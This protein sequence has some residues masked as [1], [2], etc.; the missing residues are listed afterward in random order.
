MEPL[1]RSA[2]ASANISLA[3]YWRIW[4]ER[5]QLAAIG[6]TGR[7]GGQVFGQPV[8]NRHHTRGAHWRRPGRTGSDGV[9]R[10]AAVKAAR[11]G[12]GGRLKAH[13]R[14]M[15]SR[16][17]LGLH[18]R[19]ANDIFKCSSGCS[20]GSAHDG[21]RGRRGPSRRRSSPVHGLAAECGRGRCD[22]KRT[23]LCSTGP[24]GVSGMVSPILLRCR[25]GPNLP[26]PGHAP[27]KSTRMSLPRTL[28]G[29]GQPTFS[30]CGTRPSSAIHARI[31]C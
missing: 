12:L 15:S 30:R 1:E 23:R 31:R 6:Y 26:L 7:Q 16:M 18:D 4:P 11:A 21:F 2:R 14:T 17:Q 9:F 28:K 29:S 13:A 27:R 22:R 5:N 24:R 3:G 10:A 8:G 25:T 20:V 19:E